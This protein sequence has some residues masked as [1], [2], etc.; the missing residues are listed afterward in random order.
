MRCFLL[1]LHG[2][3]IVASACDK[4]FSRLQSWVTANGG[5]S[6][7][8]LGFSPAGVRG[9][10]V[11]RACAVG[12]VLLEVPLSLVIS[13]GGEDGGVPLAGAAPAWTWELPWNIQLAVS[14][15]ER[16]ATRGASADP[17]L[18]SWPAT[19]PPLPTACD[20]AELALASD[21][22]LATKADEAFFWLSEQYCL[23]REAAAAERGVE[24]AEV[25]FATPLEFRGAMEMVWSRCLRVSTAEHGVRRVLVPLLDFANHDAT[26]S[27]MY[28]F[29]SDATCGPAIRLH[30]VRPMESGDEVTI[31]YGEH[32]STHFA[33]YY[34]FVPCP[35]P[36]DSIT[37]TL[38]DVLSTQ[39]AERVGREPEAGWAAAIE[40]AL[41][42]DHGGGDDGGGDDASMRQFEL[43]ARAPSGA[44]LRALGRLLPGGDASAARAIATTVAAIEA[45]L[46][47]LEAETFDSLD[48][49]AAVGVEQDEQMIESID[50]SAAAGSASLTE[51]G[52]LLV[53]L[54][55]SRRRLL[56]SLRRK[57]L[58]VAELC[59]ADPD[60]G[61]AAL[62]ELA[63]VADTPHS[64]YPALDV[65]PVEELS[66]WAQREW[67]W[68]RLR[69]A[70]PGPS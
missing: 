10:V 58:A 17:F 5:G 1:V 14:V 42:V 23:A 46:W 53:T 43:F 21:P 54:R 49:A 9:L 30:A 31:T 68:E 45:S 39:P 16:Q 24:P 51:Q 62:T 35:N 12:D 65:L 40:A 6:M 22:S 8:Q 61:A 64:T 36:L 19:P 3:T 38:P 66:G 4:S 44:L 26:P 32:S 34:G 20:A 28:A 70:R 69:W 29:A 56:Q 18:D 37:V 11:E 15:L 27:A 67:D 25:N 33:L 41:C 48:V 2:A 50:S 59:E 55:L 57:M 52:R 63:D 47:G 7:V 13:D 60:K